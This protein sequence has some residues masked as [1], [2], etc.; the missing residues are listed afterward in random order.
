MSAPLPTRGAAHWGAILAFAL[1][2]SLAAWARVA[3]FQEPLAG[4]ELVALD[5]DSHY[6]VRRIEA[7]LQGSI[8]TRDP[9][10]NWPGG[11]Y[12]HWAEGFDILGAGFAALAGGG[13][14]GPA[15]HLAVFLWPVVLGILA[16]WATI[17][18]TRRLVP[19]SDLATPL[20]AGLVA[21]L[22]PHFV[23]S[24]S[25]G[26]VDH[27]V[28]EALSMLLLLSWSMRR[29]PVEGEKAPEGA[30]EVA[31]AVAV[32]LALW[33][34][35]GGEFYVALAAVPL[36]L[37]A[38]APDPGRRRVVGSGAPALVAGALLGAALSVPSLRVHGRFLSFIFPSLLQPALVALAGL[39]LAGAILVGE[40]L[41]RR[42]T[43][44]RVAAQLGAAAAVLLAALALVPGLGKEV[45]GAVQGWMLHK[46]PW[47][48]TIAE[49]Q[50][51]LWDRVRGEPGLLH[52]RTL[53]GPVGIL[54]AVA[55]PLG[56]VVAWRHSPERAAS[57]A[58]AATVASAMALLQLRFTRV[59]APML[60]IAIALA[61]RGLATW[62]ERVP[63]ARRFAAWTP[64]L[65]VVVLVSASP[66]L[67]RQLEVGKPVEL[68]S[69][70]RASFA[71]RLDEP[72]V[73]GRRQGVL[74]PWDLG[75]AVMQLSGRPVASNGFGSYMDPESFRDVRDAFVGD[76]K[77]LVA[78][79]EKYD[80]GLLVG[81]GLALA[82]HQAAAAGE[83][84]VAGDPPTLNP[85][86]MRKTP[87]SQLL[88][89]G[90]GLPEAGLPHLERL[91]PIL[92]SQATAGGLSFPLPVIWAY[93]LVP[94]ATITGRTAPGAVVV[95]ELS[96]EEWGRPHRYRA[97]ARAGA[98]GGWRLRVAA[99]SGLVAHAL[100]TGP[101]WRITQGDGRVVEVAVPEDA[102][103]AGR[104]IALP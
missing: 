24:S 79:M 86:F 80:L 51:L 40:R 18:L 65:G 103:R 71:L 54:G 73:P 92:A 39:A 44:P 74:A 32:A 48:A 14:T 84:P 70:Y 34:F 64:L 7:A 78:T 63:L 55:L 87:L 68:L 91:M 30:W 22:V 83:S 66:G 72:P 93:E 96:L 102:V 81:G 47:I 11:G 43:L 53:L 67:R 35:S 69:L 15:T 94:G 1:L 36:G 45:L 20:A 46:D 13:R 62:L 2:L 6:H 16:V 82:N 57:F 52:V 76:E 95:G 33:T 61:L 50:P 19:R 97:F 75:H 60:A 37:A 12:A 89:A 58:L 90:S 25:I 59:A 17:E 23:D 99:P 28:A 8:P 100:R 27:H 41:S 85:R 88:I 101:A 26:R 38:L 21:A 29:F 56:A 4:G 98:D 9:L 77:R 42:G 3:R 104:E 49:F 5:G 31:G 10:M